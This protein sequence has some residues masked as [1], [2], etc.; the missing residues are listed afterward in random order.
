MRF[1]VDENIHAALVEWLRSAGH[2]VLYAA[3]SLSG[4]PDEVLLEVAR[5][6]E[7]I[8]VTD[9]KDFGEL[10]FHRRLVSEGILLIRLSS[11][12]IEE[13][14]RRL[15]EVW[16]AIETHLGGRFVVLGDNKVRIRP[17]TLTP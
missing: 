15:G 16:R 8:L 6:E 2:D 17:I 13:R 10:V 5:C 4:H 3:E 1:L 11:P 12:Q 14:L 9:D 7:R